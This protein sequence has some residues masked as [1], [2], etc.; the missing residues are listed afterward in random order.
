MQER[1][2]AL[3]GECVIE[4]ESGR[5]TSVYVRIPLTHADQ[6]RSGLS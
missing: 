2:E 1:V 6:E 5:G 3:G 4:S